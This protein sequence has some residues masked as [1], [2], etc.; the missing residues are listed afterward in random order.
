[1]SLI[2]L[3]WINVHEKSIS[4]LFKLLL[5]T[6]SEENICIEYIYIFLQSIKYKLN[7]ND[8]W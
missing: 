7:I 2:S 4:K 1:M 3:D 8:N 5:E 6:T